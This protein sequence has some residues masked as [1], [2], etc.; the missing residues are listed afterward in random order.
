MLLTFQVAGLSYSVWKVPS[1]QK[2]IRHSA[3]TQE[4]NGEQQKEMRRGKVLDRQLSYWLLTCNATALLF[5]VWSLGPPWPSYRASA[6][7]NLWQEEIKIQKS[8]NFWCEL[9]DILEFY[10]T[11]IRRLKTSI[12]ETAA[13]ISFR[14]FQRSAFIFIQWYTIRKGPESIYFWNSLCCTTYLLFHVFYWHGL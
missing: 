4:L 11:K 10:A 1:L 2:H 6:P 8:D 13:I 7:L 3:Q 12:D 5:L 9:K 14:I